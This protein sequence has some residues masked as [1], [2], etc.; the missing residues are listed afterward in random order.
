MPQRSKKLI[1]NP[2]TRRQENIVRR[3]KKYDD[4]LASAA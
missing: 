4:V 2:D 3:T 1:V